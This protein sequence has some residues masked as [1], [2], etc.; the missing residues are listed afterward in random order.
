[1]MS[2]KNILPPKGVPSEL[3]TQINYLA[4]LLKHL[5]LSLPLDPPDE[6]SK[7]QFRFDDGDVAEEGLYFAFNRCL[8]NCFETHLLAPNATIIFKEC[9]HRSW[10]LISML[11]RV[12]KELPDERKFISDHWVERL[13]KAAQ[14]A[15]AKIPRKKCMISK[16][17]AA[18]I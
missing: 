15:G 18:T 6:M 13:V 4:A 1:M 2:S 7:Y 12:M 17:G 16:Y 9:G 8:E 14:A 5:P 3:N 11:Q 10:A